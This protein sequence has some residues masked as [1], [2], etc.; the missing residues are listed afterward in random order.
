[1]SISSGTNGNP[2]PTPDKAAIRAAALAAIG[3]SVRGPTLAELA[4]SSGLP[5]YPTTRA[6]DGRFVP[7]R[8]SHGHYDA[9]SDAGEIRLAFSE[10]GVAGFAVRMGAASGLICIDVDMKEGKRGAEWLDANSHRLPKTLVHRTKSGAGR[11]FL[12]R[13]PEGVE[14]HTVSSRVERDGALTRG[15]A[16][17]VDLIAEGSGLPWP[18]TPGYAVVE[19]AE[20]AVLPDWL[21]ADC[22][23]VQKQPEPERAPYVAPEPSARLERYVATALV[24]ECHAVAMA[25]EGDRDAQLNRSAFNLGQ[26]VAGAGLPKGEAEAA[27]TAAGLACGL[28]RQVVAY[29]VRRSL[30]DGMAKPRAPADRPLPP[31]QRA[32]G[33]AGAE[34]APRSANGAGAYPAQ[35]DAGAE[36]PEPDPADPGPDEEG[37]QSQAGAEGADDAAPEPTDP[38]RAAAG[39]LMDIATQ[40]E[41]EAAAQVIAEGLGVPV[42]DVLAAVWTLLVERLAGLIERPEFEAEADAAAAWLG[43]AKATDRRAMASRMRSIA[44]RM[45]KQTEAAAKAA[46]QKVID[47]MAAQAD[48]AA[49]EARA[50]GAAGADNEVRELLAEFNARY[51]LVN[52]AGK[53][54]IYEEQQD[55]ILKR[56]YYDRISSAAFGEF[57]LNRLVCVGVK[58]D[59]TPIRK[60]AA[61]VWRRHPGRRQFIGGVVFDPDDSRK[62]AIAEKNQLNLWRGFQ[63]ERRPGGSWALMKAHIRDV[64]CSGNA[65]CFDYLIRWMA[66]LVQFPG[67]QGHVAVVLKGGQG[68]GKGI[69]ARSLMRLFGQHGLAIAQSKHLTG[70]FNAHQRDCVFLFADEAF[71]AGDPSVVGV[72]KSIITE[73]TLTIEGKNQNIQTCPN[74]I[75]LMM[76]SNSQWVVPA[77][78]DARRFFVLD[79]PN[80]KVGNHTYFEA[81]QAQLDE[82]GGAGYSAMLDDLLGM[83]V[84]DF[85]VRAFPMTDGLQSQKQLSL[86]GDL[87]WWSDILHRG[88]VWKSQL[89]LEGYFGKWRSFATTELLY[90]SYLEYA[91]AHRERRAMD[92]IRFGQFMTKVASGSSRPSRAHAIGEHVADVDVQGYGMRRTAEPVMKAKATG[93]TLGSLA[94]ARATFDQVSGLRTDW[95]AI[96]EGDE[97]ADPPP[98]PDADREEVPW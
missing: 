60:Q 56:F 72:L 50:A 30:R 45:A 68:C 58:P 24:A 9:T 63:V 92:R 29:K 11:H 96:A 46:R 89:G 20:P 85:N 22:M 7:L 57:W 78:L 25:P 21:L 43:I 15:L 12:F 48:A 88:Y 74:F 81:I 75:H 28:P 79:V 1:M 26:L 2:Q 51:M 83:D 42:A 66:R 23:A 33:A 47:D 44:R 70:N 38:V 19:P 87:A 69:V 93:Y 71:Y 91:G 41:R 13:L 64:L 14:L 53:A 84:R 3:R 62:A 4:I 5:V 80:T 27:L 32:E 10:P 97:V 52:E 40:V 37:W 6:D 90:A 67:E 49:A 59:G 17:H 36:P 8:G 61:E 18:G 76:A 55:S 94:Q 98:E 82:D 73:P 31:R 65:E 54:W 34:V 95:P 16:P 35:E 77:E 39:P 86:T